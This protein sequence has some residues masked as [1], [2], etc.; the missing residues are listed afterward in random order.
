M[1]VNIL[2]STRANNIIINITLEHTTRIIAG[3]MITM[4]I[5]M[6]TLLH[7]NSTH[8]HIL[9]HINHLLALLIHHHLLQE[10]ENILPQIQIIDEKAFRPSAILSN[11][12]NLQTQ[13]GEKENTQNLSPFLPV[14]HQD[15][16]PII[17]LELPH[18]YKTV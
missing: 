7:N 1:N 4:D 15:P 5:T 16:D 8:S 11:D 12:L 14:I 17:H 9:N 2:H 10:P 3:P 6:T 18:Q 13:T